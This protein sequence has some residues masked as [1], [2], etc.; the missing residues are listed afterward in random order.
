[1]LSNAIALQ[2]CVTSGKLVPLS[3]QTLINCLTE[4]LN[5]CGKYSSSQNEK[6]MESALDWVKSNG[7]PTLAEKPYSSYIS[8]KKGTCEKKVYENKIKSWS[9]V[10]LDDTNA[11]SQ[12]LLNG[13]PLVGV[14]KL[15][16]NLLIMTSGKKAT[17]IDDPVFDYGY[18]AVLITGWSDERTDQG[19]DWNWIFDTSW[20]LS[21]GYSG[22]GVFG[23]KDG[24]LVAL[25]QM[26]M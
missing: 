5:P 24:S 12:L 11:A 13:K 7:V 25:F 1:M 19:G 26:E 22:S 4:D 6:V 17:N 9:P 8:T 14:L 18:Q 23:S 21:W 3:P 10:K 15:T 16:P 2:T 20:G